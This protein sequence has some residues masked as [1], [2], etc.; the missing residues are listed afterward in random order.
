MVVLR[1][2]SPKTGFLARREFSLLSNHSDFLPFGS[3]F[4]FLGLLS[5]Q[6]LVFCRHA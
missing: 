5:V 3:L 2:I 4:P 1:M 6:E